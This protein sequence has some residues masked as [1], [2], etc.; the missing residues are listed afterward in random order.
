[1]EN[2]P[3]NIEATG[4]NA[5]QIEFWNGD[6]GDSWARHQQVMD[7]MI[8]PL[9]KVAMDECGVSSGD[10]VLD[11]GCGCGDTSLA[12]ANLGAAVTGIDISEPMLAIARNRAQST[13]GEIDFVLADALTHAF[14]RDHTLLFS[15]FGVMF[16]SDPVAGFRNLASAL[17]DAGRLS[18]ICWRPALENAWISV[19]MLAAAPFMPPLPQTDPRAPGPF[20]FADKDYIAD[21]LTSAGFNQIEINPVDESLIVGGSDDMAQAIEFYEKI[22]PMARMFSELEESARGKALDAV[23]QAVQ[24]YLLDSGLRLNSACWLVQARR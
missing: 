3:M 17:T 7:K 11:I 15:R 22:G 16:F 4:P 2:N 13:E 10:R 8:R 14:K 20:A 19:P 12:L 6:A 18:F 9:G 1:M 5:D 24:P 23:R 21:T